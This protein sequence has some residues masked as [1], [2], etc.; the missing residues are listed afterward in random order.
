MSWVKYV[1]FQIWISWVKYVMCVVILGFLGPKNFQTSSNMSQWFI[2]LTL[3]CS[4]S[5]TWP[6][7]CMFQKVI[8]AISR[9]NYIFRSTYIS[10]PL[11]RKALSQVK[12][13]RARAH[14]MSHSWSCRINN[15]KITLQSG[16]IIRALLF[17]LCLYSL[18]SINRWTFLNT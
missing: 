9:Q 15:F 11:L 16:E 2:S 4:D 3:P 7:L 18:S 6:I 8:N 1:W 14:Q 13:K 10:I 5:S 12:K 17:L